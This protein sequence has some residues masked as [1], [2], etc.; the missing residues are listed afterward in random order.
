MALAKVSSRSLSLA[1]VV[2]IFSSLTAR[3][4]LVDAAELRIENI[5]GGSYTITDDQLLDTT[6]ISSKL[7]G[8]YYI[9]S[10]AQHIIDEKDANDWKDY[11]DDFVE[12]MAPYCEVLGGDDWTK[13][14]GYLFTP[15]PGGTRVASDTFMTK[16]LTEIENEE[17]GSPTTNAAGR[18]EKV[19]KTVKDMCGIHAVLRYLYKGYE[20]N[21]DNAEWDKA[22]AAYYGK[23]RSGSVYNR[24]E[25]LGN[26]FGTMQGSYSVANGKILAAFRA[27]KETSSITVRR[28]KYEIIEH[29]M[30]IVYAQGI[31]KYAQQMD[32]A[33]AAGTAVKYMEAQAEGQA[34]A[35]ILAPWVQS[36]SPNN[37]TAFEYM[38]D[39][40]KN[41]RGY[42]N[43][44]Y[45]AA[46]A[47]LQSDINVGDGGISDSEI[48][49]YSGTEDIICPKIDAHLSALQRTGTDTYTPI[50]IVGP[51]LSVSQAVS[52][53]K[54]LLSDSSNYA[55]IK[56]K[57]TT[58]GLRALADTNRAGE[59]VWDKFKVHFGS[60]TWISD[61]IDKICD[62]TT[63]SSHPGARAEM[64]EK[65][66]LDGLQTQLILSD[67]YNGWKNSDSAKWD[68]GAAKFHGASDSYE[69]TIFSRGDKRGANYGTMSSDGIANANKKIATAL[70][71][72]GKS[73]VQYNEI[74]KQFKVIYAQ[75]TIRYAWLI[76]QDVVE[77]TDYHEHQ[78][79]GL[80]FFRV[81]APWVK[82]IDAAG[83]ET[84]NQIFDT[85][86]RPFSI[87]GHAYCLV[88]KIITDALTLS[89]T[90]MG[91]LEDAS[92]MAVCS[93]IAVSKVIAQGDTMLYT[94][95]TDIGASLQT[96]TLV[97]DIKSI[98]DVDSPNFAAIKAKYRS[99]G[100]RGMADAVRTGEPAWMLFYAYF[101]SK[102]WISDFVY[103][104]TDGTATSNLQVARLEAIE[105]SVWDATMVNAIASDLY[106]GLTDK[107]AW[108]AAAAKY[109]GSSTTR[110]TTV[111]ARA[112]KR[113]AD[114]G[115]LDSDG[116][117][118]KV[119]NA[120]SA[121]FKA[122]QS[123]TN[124]DIILKSIKTIYAQC[125]VR[126]ALLLDQ[127][128]SSGADYR[129]HQA[130][131]WAFW[132]VVAPWVSQVDSNGAQ[133]LDYIFNT[134]TT[135][136]HGSHYCFA[137]NVL[138]NLN[139]ATADMGVHT[140]APSVESCAGIVPTIIGATP[141]SG[142][143][144][145]ASKGIFF[146]YF[147]ATFFVA[148]LAAIA[149]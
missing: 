130:E 143:T 147:S 135:P 5:A 105:K 117:T 129:E 18:F 45:C 88:E 60:E 125:A 120:I 15:S 108:D 54:A 61:F 89:T 26:D 138:K 144:H 98:I 55:T 119:N 48:G 8:P 128:V 109:F 146:V 85:N 122:G 52:Q 123:Q 140:G 63:L 20:P 30:R 34:F 93:N 115:T 112:N 70:A 110:S 84:V 77:G 145:F 96:S 91:A 75:A 41:P 56:A 121:A 74:M 107:N 23:E 141:S 76:D 118:A 35:R 2:A 25:K 149:L 31:I 66:I 27:G 29:Q 73:E 142:F 72:A 68:Q 137:V 114:F 87:G 37:A 33:I 3:D 80:A 92:S 113:A 62:G 116:V 32:V 59:P 9:S 14:T 22:A 127:D 136:N 46:K 38:F 94:A 39:T 139:I 28:E 36:Y 16:Y 12:F 99:N 53:V 133:V 101:S 58:S 51:D 78:A 90:D 69:S 148:S 100:L 10:H 102:T 64:V 79:E 13:F 82:E 71:A 81:I 40:S 111:Y 57:Y 4:V 65:T 17:P 24:A 49:T 47:I 43:Y 97:S 50:S 124:H 44:N 132:R 19:E 131:G 67:L 7:A 106:R 21:L 1:C 6:N 103:R 42:A 95:T 86:K 134:A 11:K 104:A 126:Y 83:Y